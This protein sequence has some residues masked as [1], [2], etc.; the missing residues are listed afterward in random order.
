MPVSAPEAWSS[1][2][3][4]L[5]CA[6]ATPLTHCASE[7]SALINRLVICCAIAAV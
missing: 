1:S 6:E 3:S 4:T 7:Q 2:P 5:G